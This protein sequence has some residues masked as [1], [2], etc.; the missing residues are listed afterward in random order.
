MT[1]TDSIP[2]G[3]DGRP[4]SAEDARQSAGGD[5]DTARAFLIAAMREAEECNNVVVHAAFGNAV[6]LVDD[7]LRA[8][9]S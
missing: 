7:G 8:L 9:A 2:T 3:I 1:A 6:V 5:A 4:L